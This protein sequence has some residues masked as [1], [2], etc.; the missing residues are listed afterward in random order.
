MALLGD[1]S[2]AETLLKQTLAAD[3]GNVAVLLGL[4]SLPLATGQTEQAL[5]QAEAAHAA[6]PDSLPITGELA[7]LYFATNQPQKA[8]DL[9]N[10]A[11]GPGK[12]AAEKALRPVRIRAEIAL[13]NRA[14]AVALMRPMLAEAPDNVP[15]RRQ[16]ADLLA[17][18]KDYDG[19]RAVLRDGLA[20]HPGEPNLVA[21]L[22]AVAGAEG[23]P[24]AAV[25]RAGELAR[26]PA[27]P[28]AVTLKGDVLMAQ[29]HYAEA[30]AAFE[31]QLAA[32]PK[33]DPHA[34]LL[35]I[36]DA[37]A[38]AAS[39]KPDDAA[40]MLR[41]LIATHPDDGATLVLSS[42]DVA[43]RRLPQAR[44]ELETVLAHA[45]N[46]IAALNNLAWVRQQQGD[47]P[48]ARTLA[49][50]AHLLAPAPQTADTL[51]W[52]VLAQGDVSDALTLLR[53]AA[54]GRQN[55]PA[56]AYHYAAALARDGQ[57]EAA[58]TKLKAVLG[59]TVRFDEKPQA[60]KLLADLQS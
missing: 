53:S 56:I 55:D 31:A 9:A 8:L 5:A 6:A 7:N 51:G 37:Q 12:D 47:L 35:Q 22:V 52:I 16:I 29:G 59:D 28:G 27:F 41:T 17:N 46:N 38:I 40:A 18:D 4:I 33:D 23:G 42:L 57:K 60:A 10:A 34:Y 50:R 39:G 3:P 24:A 30:Q 58:V 25:A 48:A 14:A 36:G 45:P 21:G 54:L 20:R 1:P 49:E 26:D 13:G 19:A 44:A 15:L 43:A 32:L 11:G 2:G